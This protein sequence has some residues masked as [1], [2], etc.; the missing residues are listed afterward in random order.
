MLKK[1]KFPNLEDVYVVSDLHYGHDRDFI[2]GKRGFG[3]VDESNEQLV[4]EWNKRVDYTKTVI[5]LGDLLFSANEE[6]FWKL[7]DRLNFET[8][9][10]LWG[11][12]VSGQKQAYQSSLEKQFG[13]NIDFEVY[14]LRAQSPCGKNVVFLPNYVEMLVEKEFFTLFHYPIS[15]WN[16]QSHGSIMLSGHC[17]GNFAGSNPRT[18]KG[19]ILDVGIECFGGPIS[20]KF[21]VDFL[22]DREYHTVD[23][24]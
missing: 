16:G 17:H 21:V 12:H 24:H 13:S 10:L 7:V 4:L 6:R 18:G 14:P 2:W 20:L 19:K 23:H 11:N 22:K 5:H 1:L 9:Y 3:S 8:L 15:S